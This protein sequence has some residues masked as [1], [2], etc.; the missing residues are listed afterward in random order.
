MHNIIIGLYVSL[1]AACVIHVS[2]HDDHTITALHTYVIPLFMQRCND[3]D[4]SPSIDNTSDCNYNPL[5][6]HIIYRHLYIFQWWDIVLPLLI[7]HGRHWAM[8]GTHSHTFEY[9]TYNVYVS[10][11][12]LKMHIDICRDISY[13]CGI[14]C[15]TMKHAQW[16]ENIG[17]LKGQIQEVKV[18]KKGQ[19]TKL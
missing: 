2:L 14:I 1:I 7:F 3:R 19:L 13:A 17:I 16:S 9:T 10:S 12:V 11:R 8:H 4:I 18:Q 5:P 6:F 15:G